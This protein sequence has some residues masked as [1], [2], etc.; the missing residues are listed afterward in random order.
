MELS[1]LR[2]EVRGLL[3]E[4]RLKHV[5]CCES[6]AKKLAQFWGADPDKARMAALLHDITKEQNR[7]GQLKLC[8]KHSIIVGSVE[9]ME[10]KLLHAITAAALAKD[11]YHAPVDVCDAIRYHTTG[12]EN[13]TLLQKILYLA[14]FI[15]PTRDF[16]GVVKMRKLAYKDLNEAL[17]YAFDCSISEVLRHGGILHPDTVSG[18]NWILKEENLK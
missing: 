2:A 1:A 12:K 15:E 5:L 7:D 6:E 14:D 4:K 9:K 8:E 10:W 18:R 11:V 17:L 3:G 16:L 13:M